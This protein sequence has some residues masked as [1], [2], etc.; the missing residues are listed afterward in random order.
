M[1]LLH[2]FIGQFAVFPLLTPC[3]VDGCWCTS[4]SSHEQR[5]MVLLGNNSLIFANVA[6]DSWSFPGGSLTCSSGLLSA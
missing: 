2:L 3:L 4:P 1:R 6:N 5:P